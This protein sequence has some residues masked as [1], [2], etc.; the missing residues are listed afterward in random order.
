[1]SEV[2]RGC[3]GGSEVSVILRSWVQSHPFFLKSKPC[4]PFSFNVGPLTEELHGEKLSLNS[5]L[6]LVSFYKGR[7]AL[8]LLLVDRH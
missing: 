1:M 4:C 3:D 8:N 2:L 5:S 6:D 7:N